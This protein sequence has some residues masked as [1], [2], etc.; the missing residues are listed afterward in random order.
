MKDTKYR[1]KLTFI[2]FRLLLLFSIFFIPRIVSS[3]QPRPLTGVLFSGR[4]V[5]DSSTGS[6]TY[7]YKV[8]NP[9]ENNVEIFSIDIDLTRSPDQIILSSQ[10]LVNGP[11]YSRYG[12]DYTLQRV[13]T[14]P[15]GI[16]GPQG[17]TYAIGETV[18]AK[19][20]FGSWG[21]LETFFVRSGTS[22]EGFELK[23]YGLPGL[24]EVR[25]DPWVVD[26]VPPELT[27]WEQLNAFYSQ[28][29]FRTKTIGPV[30]PKINFVPI[31]FLNYLISLVHESYSL[32]WIKNSGIQQSLLAKLTNAKRQLEKAD[33]PSAKNL[34]SAF[35]NEI[36]GIS[37]QEFSC[38][39]NQSLTS[40]GY[41]L[42]F[43]NGQYLFD[44]L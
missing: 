30:A 23:S 22:L 15:V 40:E 3:Q 11:R 35:L 44:R 39:N 33:N 19:Q 41:Y 24:R 1:P 21:S 5:R 10:G 6:Y 25:V 20:S 18:G 29:T 13:P 34:I 8:V 17:W 16:T 38:P 32:G 12:S 4:V 28:F 9:P 36:N 7:S 37:C 14:V 26:Y 31:D 43:F 2:I 27:E 42:L